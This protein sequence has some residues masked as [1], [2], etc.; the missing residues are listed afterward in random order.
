MKKLLLITQKVDKNY[1]LL[2]FFIDW[3]NRF[4]LKFD[5]I[6]IICLEKGEF[7]LPDNVEVVSMGKDRGFNKLSQL[8]TFYRLIGTFDYDAVFVHMN[9]IWVVL[10]GPVWRLKGK[11]IYFWY[12]HKAV[13]P[14]L[15]LAE[16]FADVIFTA[17]KESFRLPSKK[18][19]VTG[20]GINTDLF[21]PEPFKREIISGLKI[22]SVGRISPVKNYGTLIEAVKILKDK[23]I[24]FSV[25]MI[26]EPALDSDRIYEA[27]I[28][29]RIKELGLDDNF[30]FAGKI[31]HSN[32]P[33]YYKSSDIF[34]HLSKTGSVD[35][36]ILEAMACGMKVLSS[37]D[38][39]RAFLPAE[40]I[41]DESDP[42]ELAVKILALKDKPVSPALREYVVTNHNLDSLIDKISKKI[43]ES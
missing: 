28:K 10:G 12:T 21:R 8:A 40:L 17:S 37:N 16:K 30:D 6:T 36:T 18:V 38:S 35:K 19:I 22:L 15:R 11:K 24:E 4:A 32:L 31:S 9:P 3:L 41:F 39:A 42:L 2:G 1:Q 14:K 27:K 23:N 26:G 13:T 7:K 34:I 20:H 5:K 33:G 43:I 25:S 29:S